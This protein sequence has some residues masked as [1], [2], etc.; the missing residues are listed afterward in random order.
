MY[1]LLKAKSLGA[2]AT[3]TLPPCP[4]PNFIFEICKGFCFHKMI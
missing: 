2:D 1:T 4:F 3:S